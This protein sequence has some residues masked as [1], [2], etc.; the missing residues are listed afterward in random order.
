MKV[1]YFIPWINNE[2]KKNVQKSLEQRWL[3]NGPILKKFE[4]V[5]L[6]RY[7]GT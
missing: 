1:P 4:T 2:D 7:I 5:D 3:T 6:E